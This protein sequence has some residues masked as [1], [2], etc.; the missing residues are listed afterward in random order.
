MSKRVVRADR[1][2]ANVRLHPHPDALASVVGDLQ[3]IHELDARQREFQIAGKERGLIAGSEEEND[4]IVVL[5]RFANPPM[6]R[7]MEHC[8]LAELLS[9]ENKPQRN[10]PLAGRVR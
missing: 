8:E 1:D 6:I 3:E 4:R 5:R 2:H 9:G 7:R 10:A